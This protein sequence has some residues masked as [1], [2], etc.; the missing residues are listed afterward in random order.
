M[1]APSVTVHVTGWP[2]SSWPARKKSS[3]PPLPRLKPLGSND[4]SPL[5]G[6]VGD[7]PT[8]SPTTCFWIVILP[9]V[10]GGLT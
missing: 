1:T 2:L 3:D 10:G 5:N 4:R 7:V 8:G 9:E 6:N